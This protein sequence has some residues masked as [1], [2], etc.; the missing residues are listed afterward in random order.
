MADD[1][2]EDRVRQHEHFQDA[3]AALVAAV[4]WTTVPL[5]LSYP[6][7]SIPRFLP[8]FPWGLW[9]TLHR[10]VNSVASAQ[11]SGTKVPCLC[12]E[13]VRALKAGIRV[14]RDTS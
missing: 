8:S 13:N 5:P 14:R 4:Q 12:P 7:T 3:L 11:A 9:R 2:H 6:A 1:A 10:W